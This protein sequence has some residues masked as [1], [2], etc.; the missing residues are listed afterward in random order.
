[1]PRGSV[2]LERAPCE[3]FVFSAVSPS[4]CFSVMEDDEEEFPNTRTDEFLHNSNG[5][6]KREELRTPPP[7]VIPSFPIRFHRRLMRLHKQ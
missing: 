2:S 1:M 6:E 7:P 3:L 4:V 5:K